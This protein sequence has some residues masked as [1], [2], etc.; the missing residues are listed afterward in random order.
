MKLITLKITNVLN[1]LKFLYFLID[2]H[3]KETS[4]ERRTGAFFGISKSTVHNLKLRK[5]LI[6]DEYYS[7]LNKK[8]GKTSNSDLANS[9]SVI[10]NINP[11]QKESNLTLSNNDPKIN[12]NTNSSKSNLATISN[13]EINNSTTSK[14]NSNLVQYCNNDNENVA[15]I[16]DKNLEEENSEIHNLTL[17]WFRRMRSCNNRVSLSMIQNAA[18]EFA[19]SLNNTSFCASGSWGS[20]LYRF[21]GRLKI[22]TNKQYSQNNNFDDIDRIDSTGNNNGIYKTS[23]REQSAAYSPIISL[24]SEQIIAQILAEKEENRLSENNDLNVASTNG[25][26]GNPQEEITEDEMSLMFAKMRN[27]FSKNAP[28]LTENLLELE[29]KLLIVN[30]KRQFELYQPQAGKAFVKIEKI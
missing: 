25:E 23:S 4:S 15:N 1:E 7:E 17:E 26:N 12:D 10:H 28:H 3:N 2:Q 9:N 14:H 13:P 22:N 5:K 11:H 18:L 20:W 19:K 24:T 6:L 30:A 8:N 21:N 29:N 16:N 27:Y